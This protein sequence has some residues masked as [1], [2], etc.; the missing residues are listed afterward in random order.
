MAPITSGSFILYGQGYDSAGTR[1]YNVLYD[2][3]GSIANSIAQR[4]NNASLEAV[5]PDD[6]N[7]LTLINKK[8]ADDNYVKKDTTRA[9]VVY[10]HDFNLNPRVFKVDNSNA[11][12]DYLAKYSK[13]DTVGNVEPLG[14]GRLCS[15]E[16]TQPYQLANR[17]F[18]EDAIAKINPQTFKTLFGNRSVV[19]QGNIDLFKHSIKGVL[20]NSTF[21][22]R[23]YSS[24][25]L[26]ANSL[27]DLK[28]LLGDTFEESVTGSNGIM[29]ITNEKVLYENGT[30]ASIAGYTITDKVTTI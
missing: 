17:K 9:T 27:T 3:S 8:C 28:T 24:N 13:D 30:D 25:N 11:K 12:P 21:Y 4:K 29:A 6:P 2:V 16:P 15:K 18:V 10:G 7:D 1:P 26:Q 23:I 5:F 20:G 19:G 22:L 14:N